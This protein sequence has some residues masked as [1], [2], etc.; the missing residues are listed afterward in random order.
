L[1]R[2]L[3]IADVVD[4]PAEVTFTVDGQSV[5][6]VPGESLAVALLASGMRRLRSSPRNGS[7]RGL[8]CMMGI[9]QECV[10]LVDGNPLP[11]CLEPV[12][13][14]MAVTLRLS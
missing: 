3:R 13:A 8:F 9:C 14:G 7:G 1:H 10:V 5:S 4:R 2:V 6:G 12:R 11:A